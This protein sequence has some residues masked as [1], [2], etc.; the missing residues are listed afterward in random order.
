MQE[1]GVG[2]K[3]RMPTTF[4]MALSSRKLRPNAFSLGGEMAVRLKGG[5]DSDLRTSRELADKIAVQIKL[6]RAKS[7]GWTSQQL[8]TLNDIQVALSMLTNCITY[9]ALQIRDD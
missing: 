8:D 2:G 7:T 4:A 5:F 1:G 9:I 3:R 6:E